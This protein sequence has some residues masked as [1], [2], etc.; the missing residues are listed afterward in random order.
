MLLRVVQLLHGP[1][2]SR[3]GPSLSNQCATGVLFLSKIPTVDQVADAFTKGLSAR[4]FCKHR[5]MYMYH[6]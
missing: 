1:A 2:V 4:L 3:S 6:P 5:A